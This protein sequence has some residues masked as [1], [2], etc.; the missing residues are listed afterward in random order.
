MMQF[1]LRALVISGIWV[2]AGCRSKPA[3]PKEA[4][5]PIA[6]KIERFD[7]AFF[8]MDTA[9]L[10]ADLQSLSNNYPHFFPGYLTSVLGIL[11]NDPQAMEAVKAFTSS[12]ATVYRQ[13]NPVAREYLPTILPTLKE[14]LQW[15]AYL[16]PAFTPD[17]PFVITTFI[18]PMDAYESFSVG[19]YGEVRTTNGAGV[20]LQ[21]HLGASAEVYEQGMQTGIFNYYQV[22]RFEPEMIPVNIMKTMVDDLYPYT[23]S[24]KQLVEEMIEKG[25]RM[26]LVKRIMPGTADSLLLGYT[27][28]QLEGCLENEG[29]IWNFFV[30]NDLLYSI[31]PVINQQYIRDGPKTPELGEA[32]PGYIGLFTGWRIVEAYMEKKE[33]LS[34]EKLMQTPANTILQ[35]SGYRPR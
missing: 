31:D 26:Y 10:D 21:F 7:S 8:A 6:I 5:R 11:P 25:K 23:A 4:Q 34:I 28:K 24:G 2:F 1:I 30:K 22:R 15:L 32:S 16:A 14:S 18:G 12:Y 27:G 17:S 9:N 13:A 33:N 19:D 35:G 20:A 29:L 3:L